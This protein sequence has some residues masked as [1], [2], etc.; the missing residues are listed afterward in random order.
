MKRWGTAGPNG[1]S[2]QASSADGKPSEE[3][4]F[5]RCPENRGGFRVFRGAGNGSHHIL[6][7]QGIP[8]F[9]NLQNVSGQAKLY[10]LKQLLELVE[11]YGLS[12]ED[13]E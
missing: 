9:L 8:E 7:R 3:F 12:V 13:E 2:D 4:S 1:E 11:R 10:Q 5:F 6:K